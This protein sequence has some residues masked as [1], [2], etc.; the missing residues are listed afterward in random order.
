MLSS[1]CVS[2]NHVHPVTTLLWKRITFLHLSYEK[3]NAPINE[4]LNIDKQ[5]SKWKIKQLSNHKRNISLLFDI[6]VYV[7]NSFAAQLYTDGHLP[8]TVSS[9]AFSSCFTLSVYFTRAIFDARQFI[10]SPVF[11][12]WQQWA[13]SRKSAIFSSLRTPLL[14]V[15]LELLDGGFICLSKAS[16]DFIFSMFDRSWSSTHRSH[17]GSPFNVYKFGRGYS[18]SSNSRSS[19]SGGWLASGM[20]ES[21]S[22]PVS[23]GSIKCKECKTFD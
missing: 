3:V 11:S 19:I 21:G 5:R 14:T 20:S 2:D 8:G 12:I 23:W 22:Y 17:C 15:G 13:C 9:S 16:L 6:H 10:F 7:P 4:H 18:L 1:R